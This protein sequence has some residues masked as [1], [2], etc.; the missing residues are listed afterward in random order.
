MPF[1]LKDQLRQ[2]IKTSGS[3]HK[4]ASAFGMGVLLGIL[5]GTGAVVAAGLATV[6]RLNLPLAVAGAMVVNP[7]TAPLVYGASYF[8]GRWMLGDRVVEHKI[9]QI[10]LTTLTGNLVMALAM[11]LAGYLIVWGWVVWR[12]RRATGGRDAARH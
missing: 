5:P 2:L 9:T 8:L 7:L 3:P 12:R 4:L 1:S 6:L 11:A 10:L